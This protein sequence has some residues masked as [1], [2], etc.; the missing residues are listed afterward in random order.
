LT[1]GSIQHIVLAYVFGILS[2]SSR[3]KFRESPAG[4][5]GRLRPSAFPL[6]NKLPPHDPCSANGPSAIDSVPAA[7][8]T[9]NINL[10]A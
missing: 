10:H 9:H 8:L 5:R 4:E 6:E 7:S 2:S 1:E 3:R